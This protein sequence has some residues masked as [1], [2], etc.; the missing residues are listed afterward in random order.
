MACPEPSA[1]AH[2]RTAATAMAE[3]VPAT[4][5]ASV[6]EAVRIADRV[7]IA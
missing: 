5:N 7:N 3:D 1:G 2:G 4:R 6:V